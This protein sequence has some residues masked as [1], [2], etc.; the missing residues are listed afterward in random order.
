M[1]SHQGCPDAKES[2]PMQCSHATELFSEF[3]AGET[4]KATNVTIEAHLQTCADCTQILSQLRGVWSTLDTLEEVDT[5]M[6]FHE[7]IMSRL[8][9]EM[10]SAEE[11][12]QRKSVAWNWKMLFQPRT[13]ATAAALLVLI[14]A[15]VE[16]V[17]S[18]R[19]ELG[20]FSWM[21]SLFKPEL[22]IRPNLATRKATFAPNDEGGVTVTIHLKAMTVKEDVPVRYTYTLHVKDHPE[23][24][25]EGVV[26]NA[27]EETVILKLPSAPV[28]GA[29]SISVKPI[30]GNGSGIDMLIPV[31]AQLPVDDVGAGKP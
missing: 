26:T 6:Y 11:K 18:S 14:L 23:I 7:N 30:K 13:F 29:L 12:V 20:P 15:G 10:L 27:D 31:S 24:A 8:D 1:A 3:I 21:V 19:A 22:E 5:P 17:Q 25:P 2:I 4:D 28:K 16:G 9:V